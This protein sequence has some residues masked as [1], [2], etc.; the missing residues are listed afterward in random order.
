MNN[1]AASGIVER[2]LV[3]LPSKFSKENTTNLYKF[4]TGLAEAFKINSDMVDELVRQT[5][6]TSASGEYVDEYIED[7]ISLGRKDGESDED[8]KARYKNLTFKYNCSKNGIESIVI[9]LMGKKPVNMYPLVKR[10]AYLNAKFYYNDSELRSVYGSDLSNPYK[11]YIEFA[12]KPNKLIFDD[13]CRYIDAS[14]ACGVKVYLYYPQ[15]NDLNVDEDSEFLE[16]SF[17]RVI[18]E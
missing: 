16:G 14:R 13:M 11:A 3:T 5:N 1:F 15:Y 4:L 6:L 2:I 17:E 7:L 10:G 8:Y 18:Y 12:R 9:D